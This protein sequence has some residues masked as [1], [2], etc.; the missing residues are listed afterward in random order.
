MLK[1]QWV[2]LSTLPISSSLFDL[3]L[4][5]C[6]QLASSL[7]VF[8]RLVLYLI[9]HFWVF[10]NH[11]GE[12]RSTNFEENL[13]CKVLFSARYRKGIVFR[14]CIPR[15]MTSPE[16]PR[17]ESKASKSRAA[18]NSRVNYESAT[19]QESERPEDVA[20]SLVIGHRTL[21]TSQSR[22]EMKKRCRR[23][24]SPRGPIAPS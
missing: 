7:F 13:R 20:P 1:Y 3:A 21:A 12:K 6:V 23:A 11:L 19:V 18:T 10:C 2:V 4:F 14:F 24:R 5:A 9:G 22:E 8:F 17:A 15:A 16:L